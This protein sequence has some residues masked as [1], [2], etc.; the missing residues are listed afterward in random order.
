VQ[1]TPESQPAVSSL[2][3][4]NN[5]E[6]APMIT[7]SLED[8]N[9]DMLATDTMRTH[10]EGIF[11]SVLQE[12]E[13]QLDQQL[14]NN[15]NKILSLLNQDTGSYYSFKG[16]MRKLG[17]HQQSLARALNR[18]EQCGL[19][20]RSSNGYRLNLSK[21][22]L[23]PSRDQESNGKYTQGSF[24]L[25][26]Q[27]YIPKDITGRDIMKALV[28]R[29][30]GKLRWIGLTEG[31]TGHSMHWTNEENSFQVNL[32]LIWNSVVIESNAVSN[33]D[34]AEAM[35]GCFKMFEQITK[36]LQTTLRNKD[37]K[38]FLHGHFLS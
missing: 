6:G 28:G 32:K 17:I 1:E 33:S 9:M 20:T 38:K 36:I 13:R 23:S 7:E 15:D 3:A 21:Q 5:L 11:H 14:R 29:W 30:F 19:V 35:I 16:L 24:N 12:S 26:L 27:T 34:K 37:P 18:L 2:S 25:L 31:E 10:A 4:P 22:Q 8:N